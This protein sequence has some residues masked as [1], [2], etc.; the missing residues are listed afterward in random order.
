MIGYVGISPRVRRA[1][2][3]GPDEEFFDF[4]FLDF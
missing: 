2:G 4:L 1:Y 3:R